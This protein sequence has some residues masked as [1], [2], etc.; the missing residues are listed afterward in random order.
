MTDNETDAIVTDLLLY[1]FAIW[2]KDK[3]NKIIHVPYTKSF[4]DF[5]N[6]NPPAR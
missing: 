1:G 6:K 5:L 2:T 3:D 4:L